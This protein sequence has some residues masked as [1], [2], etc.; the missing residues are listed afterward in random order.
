VDALGVEKVALVTGGS[1]GGMV[2]L[3]WNLCHPGRAE[4]TLVLAAPAATP[5]SA[6]A[7]NH[8]QRRAVELAGTDGLALARMV[9][10]MT[11][12]TEA[13]FGQRFGR[14]RDQEG[15]FEAANYLTRHGDKLVARFDLASYRALLGAMDAHDIGR[16]RGGLGPALANLTGQVTAV[17]VPGDRLYDSGLV[18]EWAALAGAEYHAIDSIHGHD[19]FLIEHAQVGRILRGLLPVEVESHH[20]REGGGSDGQP[21]HGMA[22]C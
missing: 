22:A 5:A 14:A 18:R 8:I 15:R 2:A 20:P 7:W 21:Q 1:L 4:R 3:E 9:A 11:Y 10:M 19:A 12:R 6:V 17:G 13:E 16:G